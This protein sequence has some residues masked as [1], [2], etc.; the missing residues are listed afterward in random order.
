MSVNVLVQAI[1]RHLLTMF[2]GAGIAIGDDMIIQGASG[3]VALAGF[4]WSIWQKRQ[5][6]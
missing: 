4:A 2:G 5:Q 3:I 6:G 1:I